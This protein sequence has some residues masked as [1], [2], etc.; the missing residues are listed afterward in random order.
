[1]QALNLLGRA[2]ERD[3]RSTPLLQQRRSAILQ[4]LLAELVSS[5]AARMA[6]GWLCMPK[7]QART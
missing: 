2:I 1:V 5:L 6:S 3:P 7:F 4:L